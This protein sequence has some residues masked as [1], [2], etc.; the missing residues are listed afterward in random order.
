V[1]HIS[2]LEIV[3]VG[4]VSVKPRQTETNFKRLVHA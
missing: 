4:E 1:I 3:F 2:L